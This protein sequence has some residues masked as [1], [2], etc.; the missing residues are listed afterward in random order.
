MKVFL[1]NSS[2]RNTNVS[3]IR[4]G[5][6]II[7]LIYSEE[8]SKSVD[9]RFCLALALCKAT[10]LNFALALSIIACET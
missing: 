10:L 4:D 5:S 6:L 2:L 9:K 1:W 8:Q 3:A 7:S